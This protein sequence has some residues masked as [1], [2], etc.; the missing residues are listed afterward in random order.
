MNATIDIVRG[1]LE[2]LFS[3]E[4]LQKV[5]GDLLG[6]SPEDVGGTSTKAT[7]ARALTERC[8]DGQRLE[9]LVDVVRVQ[10]RE[11]DPRL[12][13]LGALLGKEELPAGRELGEF[14]IQKK[15]G[16]SELSIVYLATAGG[17]QVSLKVLRRDAARD[18][19]ATH[20]FLT[21]NRLVAALDHPGLPRSL[22][23]GE[24]PS[25]VF[26]VAYEHIEGIT[27]AARLARTGPAHVNELKAL[28]RG[29]LEPLAAMHR[30]HL[31][32]GNLKLENVLVTKDG[33][34]NR[35]VLIDFGADRL[36]QKAIAAN[37]H[38]GVLAVLGS[39]KTIAPEVVRGKQADAQSD[40][41]AFG[42]MMYELVSGKPVF[43]GETAT[44]TVFQHIAAPPEPPS[45]KA[46]RGWV[47]KEVDEL[48]LSMLS[49]DPARRPKDAQAVLDAL[50]GLGRAVVASKAQPIAPEKVEQ[51]IELLSTNPDDS[52]SAMELEKAV[53]AGADARKVAEAFA[54]AAA[55]ADA[56][57][58]EGKETA[59][60]LYYRAARIFDSAVKD[61]GQAEAM[62]IA[63][64]SI[65]PSDDIASIGLEEVRKALGKYEEIVEMLLE[66]SQ[67]AAPG[68]DRGRA[69]AE[70]GRLYGAELDDAD[71]APEWRFYS[72]LGGMTAIL[73]PQ[74]GVGPP[75]SSSRQSHAGNIG[76]HLLRFVFCA[77]ILRQTIGLRPGPRRGAG[78]GRG[79]PGRRREPTWR[80]RARRTGSRASSARAA[81]NHSWERREHLDH[82][83]RIDA[84]HQ[85]RRDAVVL[86]EHHLVDQERPG[87]RDLR[88]RARAGDHVRVLVEVDAVLHDEDVRVDAEDLV[89]ELALEARGDREHDEQRRDPERDARD[90]DGRD[91]RDG[92]AGRAA[93]VAEADREGVGHAWAGLRPTTPAPRGRWSRRAFRRIS[94]G[95]RASLG[96]GYSTS[97]TPSRPPGLDLHPTGR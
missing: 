94:V 46:P 49:K 25:G 77:N 39:P 27:L 4:E 82:A 64:L 5:S 87:A 11:V 55:K 86:H 95:F 50:E 63:I 81:A 53:D 17:K 8:L 14:T 84:F 30:A 35:A 71:Q 68:E 57:T 92:A 83:L 45:A 56:T 90:R 44:D 76:T 43:A 16:E 41:Y 33:A 48:V 18:L 19:R 80:T 66:R 42:S 74:E 89:A 7:F 62:Y 21:A 13:D 61:K 69:L 67:T 93:E 2:R 38:S 3:L 65:D 22:R 10:K 72:E 91:R 15:L 96:G 75:V 51:L 28:M 32:H 73:P 78:R 52:E 97:R 36:R 58:D 59:K 6:L 20:R 37:G 23:A 29:I 9:A 85:H 79:A 34:E 60:G 88:H 1:E 31:A 70:I 12:F 47:S 26:Y 54:A 24:I 40:V